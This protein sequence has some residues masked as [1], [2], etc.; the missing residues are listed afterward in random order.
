MLAAAHLI[1]FWT[2]AIGHIEDERGEITHITFEDIATAAG[3]R[4]SPKKFIEALLNARWLDK[5]DNR[6]YIHDWNEY[7]GKL[8]RK[9]IYD[10]QTEMRICRFKCV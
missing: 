2:W 1:R 3:W 5:I 7:A 6:L 9:R 10:R 8:I 4:K